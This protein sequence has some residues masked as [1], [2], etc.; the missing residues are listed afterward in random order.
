MTIGNIVASFSL[1][2]RIDLK[3]LVLKARNVSFNPR[4]FTGA[5]MRL[6]DPK[7]TGLFFATGKVVVLGIKS[8]EALSIA[9]AR[10]KIGYTDAQMLYLTIHN[11]TA[12]AATGY[13]I[14]LEGLYNEH[15]RFSTYEP[16]LFHGLYYR[17]LEPKVCFIIFITGT[18][19]ACGASTWEDLIEGY[20]KLLPVLQKFRLKDS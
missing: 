4:K 16:E 5:S 6:R 7:C 13:R 11:V 10:L 9:A 3:Q 20:E 19:T 15:Y 8:Q 17:M 1:G 14:R 12:S 2:H 18:I